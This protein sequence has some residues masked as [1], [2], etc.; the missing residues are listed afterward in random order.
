MNNIPH[1]DQDVRI[2]LGTFEFQSLWDFSLKWLQPREHKQCSLIKAIF[3][4]GFSPGLRTQLVQWKNSYY[5]PV[6]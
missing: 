6:R 5:L 4:C 2:L 3:T 1:A